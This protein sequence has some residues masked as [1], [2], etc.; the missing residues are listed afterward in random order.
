MT[1]EQILEIADKSTTPQEAVETIWS[2]LCKEAIQVSE[3]TEL[4]VML[5]KTKSEVE[6]AVA[7]QDIRLISLNTGEAR[8]A[9]QISIKYAKEIK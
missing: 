5:H 7:P 2:G 1:R 8:H 6:A 4:F 9:M 3:N